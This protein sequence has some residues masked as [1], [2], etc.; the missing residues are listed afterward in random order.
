MKMSAVACMPLLLSLSNPLWSAD[1][2]YEAKVTGVTP[3]STQVATNQQ[4]PECFETKPEGFADILFWDLGCDSP[5]NITIIQYQVSY[6]LGNKEF[7]RMQPTDPGETIKVK[8]NA[9]P[10]SSKKRS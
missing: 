5:R 8:L 6:R 7:T 4:A 10:A 1:F 3:I 2:F 9:V